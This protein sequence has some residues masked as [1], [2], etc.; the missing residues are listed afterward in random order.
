MGYR[1]TKEEVLGYRRAFVSLINQG[2]QYKSMSL[3]IFGVAEYCGMNK[4]QDWFR[5]YNALQGHR[6]EWPDPEFLLLWAA[7]RA[8]GGRPPRNPDAGPKRAS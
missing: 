7:V 8:P 6:H 3:A 5:V 1:V 2:K 4:T